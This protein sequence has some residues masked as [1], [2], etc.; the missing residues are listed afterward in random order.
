MTTEP[1]QPD[2]TI[3]T[4]VDHICDRFEQA[5]KQ[6]ER[7]RI[8]T[9]LEAATP[10]TRLP[11]LRELLSAELEL[12]RRA[13]EPLDRDEYRRRFPLH[14]E[15]L[16]SVWGTTNASGAW[17]SAPVLNNDSP[18]SAEQVTTQAR[19]NE[20]RFFRRGGL[21]TLFQATDA[22]LHRD[23]VVK[24]INDA[25]MDD[26]EMVNQFRLEAE[27]TS[28]LD[29]PGVVPVYAI[30]QDWYGRPFYVMRLIRG[31]ELREAIADFHHD[32][33]L[34]GNSIAARQR[35]CGL[36]EHL[37]S[38]CN[39]VA[40]AHDVGI[41]HCDI[42][43]ANIMIGKYGETFVLDWGLART[44]ERT[45]TFQAPN[46]PTMRPRSGSDSAQRGGTYG[47]ISPEQLS[48]A[49]AI[50]PAS[51]VYS[52]GA[53]LYEILTG[54]APFN[55]RDPD[56]SERIARGDF[57]APRAVNPV[58]APGLEMIC[59]KAMNVN[60]AWRYSTGKQMAADLQA[61]MRDEPLIA[62]PDSPL[63]TVSR[64]SRRHRAAT[65][66]ALVA[67][68]IV[69]GAIMWIGLSSRH[70][71]REAELR[72][73][74]EG[75]FTTALDTFEDLCRPLANG[76][77]NNLAIFRPFADR[78]ELFANDYLR[79]FKDDRALRLQAARVYELRATVA[80]MTSTDLSGPLDD[81]SQAENLY[82]REHPEEQP[83]EVKLRLSQIHLS[84]G[85]LLADQKN[86]LAALRKL[87]D[88]ESLLSRL[89]TQQ[90]DSI[91]IKRSL[92]E[93]YH[94]LGEVYLAREVDLDK[95]KQYFLQSKDLREALRQNTGAADQLT[96]DRDLARSLGYLGDLNLAQGQ[97]AVAAEQYAD[98][99]QLRAN[100]YRNSPRDPEHRFQ[101]AR[102][103]INFGYLER[104]YRG[105]C[106]EAIPKL[107]EAEE[108]QARLVQ[109]FPE[110]LDFRIDY[111]WTLDL[112][113]E[114]Y[115][116][117]STSE[118]DK[119]AEHLREAR[120]RAKQAATLY[121][122]MLSDDQQRHRVTDANVI[123]GLATS[124]VIS[125][126]IEQTTDP[127]EAARLG[128]DAVRLI[129]DR[130]GSEPLLNREELFMLALAQAV[131]DKNAEAIAT[132]DEAAAK[133][134][135]TAVRLEK[136]AQLGF[137]SLAADPQ[138]KS[139]FETLLRT[140]TARLSKP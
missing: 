120:S 60:R 122:R 82:L 40:Y 115:L 106:L 57:V 10:E 8:E 102:G 43:P 32:D 100:L 90:P 114:V 72:A 126:A 110:V 129:R 69:T 70:A 85:R 39:T 119:A 108:I 1:S 50:T 46:E 81:L 3:L 36:L 25:C 77:M 42:K 9:F 56:V 29:H 11:L 140:V 111:G 55:G 87:D 38:A 112:L 98:S 30:G 7:P 47:Y 73:R 27:I 88:A 99:L 105:Q 4:T 96:Y 67:T 59:L 20:L 58:V 92:A 41:V 132:L 97:V 45:P 83:A 78:I 74:A 24:F 107:K 80:H 89:V 68:L 63:E 31:R 123:D 35:L 12:R 134:F 18:K 16:D 103:L 138:L 117:A 17:T 33:G 51:D 86:F 137:R 64:L 19:F 52:L 135:N 14:V 23:T 104:G 44:F 28:R 26:V 5:W 93:T 2:A 130:L 101:Y 94:A 22:D 53:T 109:E 79:R 113:A 21:G 37:V 75:N 62:A 66:A 91:E 128:S 127:K 61:W 136:H 95:A 71:A 118:P 133:G 54:Q 48:N 34:R 6:G 125:A 131:Q 116:F 76:E 139:R 124:L 49:E 65:V 121:G 13:A 84:Q 15:L